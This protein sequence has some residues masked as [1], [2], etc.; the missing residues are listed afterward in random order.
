MSILGYYEDDYKNPIAYMNIKG[1]IVFSNDKK[2]TNYKKL[3]SSKELHNILSNLDYYTHFYIST[4]IN[5]LQSGDKTH[6]SLKPSQGSGKTHNEN[7][8][9]KP[10]QSGSKT[11]VSLKPP[12]GGGGG[13][14]GESNG[15][16]GWGDFPNC[17]FFNCAPLWQT[18]VWPFDITM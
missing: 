4:K 7:Y 6:V 15:K 2:L 3:G 18:N 1:L 17:C 8:S 10:S 11:H 5:R 16:C 9:L 12:Q 13:L 14:F